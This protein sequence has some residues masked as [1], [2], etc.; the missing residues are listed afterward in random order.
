MKRPAL[1]AVLFSL[2]AGNACQ[3]AVADDWPQWRGP[4]RTGISEET[5]L[6][7]EWPER[8]LKVFW[9]AENVGQAYSTVSVAN[10][11]VFTIG[12]VGEEGRI[13]CYDE[14]TGEQ[15]WSVR[16][17]TEKRA[18]SHNRGDG[19]AARPPSMGTWSTP[20]AGKAH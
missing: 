10:G 7:K 1:F 8:G 19:P 9:K 15:I 14:K 13:Q 4:N 11:R 17:P 12:N 5:G 18:F 3:T 20:K 2:F 16:P 6:L